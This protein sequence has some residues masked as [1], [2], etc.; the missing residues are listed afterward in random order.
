MIPVLRQPL[1]L[2]LHEERSLLLSLTVSSSRQFSKLI[3]IQEPTDHITVKISLSYGQQACSF[4][5]PKKNQRNSR[6]LLKELRGMFSGFSISGMCPVICRLKHTVRISSTKILCICRHRSMIRESTQQM[7]GLRQLFDQ[8]AGQHA[9]RILMCCQLLRSI[10]MGVY[11]C[12]GCR[13]RI[14]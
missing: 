9:H 11:A 13:K 8:V 3:S 7:I 14:F 1:L 2:L 12:T 5:L 6:S 4:L 10:R